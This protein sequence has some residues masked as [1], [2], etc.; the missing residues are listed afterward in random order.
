MNTF[1]FLTLL[2]TLIAGT[3]ITT[4]K[5]TSA[6]SELVEDSWSTKASMNQARADL[7][8]VVVE[9]K[10]WVMSQ[11]SLRPNSSLFTSSPKRIL[12]ISTDL[13]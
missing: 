7:G 5:P 1:V 2:F 8:V 11:N 12:C 9:G 4:L 13:E 10:I 6:S 3:F